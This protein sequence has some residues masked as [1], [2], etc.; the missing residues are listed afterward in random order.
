VLIIGYAYLEVN[1]SLYMLQATTKN[2][3]AVSRYALATDERR[4]K[5]EKTMDAK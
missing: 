5:D 1:L 2:G 3:A 4:D